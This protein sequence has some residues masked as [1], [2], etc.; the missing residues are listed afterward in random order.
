MN[1]FEEYVERYRKR[2]EKI[3]GAP[4]ATM[5]HSNRTLYELLLR[6]HET[7][8]KEWRAGRPF[9]ITADAAPYDLIEA[10]GMRAYSWEMA[11]DFLM[12]RFVPEYLRRI[13]A[14]GFP[15]YGCD[16]VQLAA[17][18]IQ[19]ADAGE[20]PKPDCVC[21]TRADCNGMTEALVWAGRHFGVPT[22]VLDCPLTTHVPFEIRWEALQY[23]VE[24]FHDMI[25]LF[26]KEIPGVKYDEAKLRESLEIYAQS[27]KYQAKFRELLKAKPCPAAGRDAG[28][29]P[30]LDIVGDPLI[31][32]YYREAAEEIEE[33]VKAGIGGAV[34]EEK[35]R[36]GFLSSFPFF[37]DGFAPLE[38]R[39]VA[40]P[41]YEVGPGALPLP[42]ID[43]ETW[44]R[45]LTPL[46]CQAA[47]PLNDPW[48]GVWQRRYEDVRQACIDLDLDGLVH[49]AMP[50]CETNNGSGRIL[51]KKLEEE[52]GVASVEVEY[53]CQDEASFNQADYVEKMHDFAELLIQ[54]KE[55]KARK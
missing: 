48:L 30:P 41:Y 50:G 31:V 47:W 37:I 42:T 39:G 34:K 23:V 11:G 18:F 19:A 25:R 3:D 33:R 24:Q 17:S 27:R 38:E 4:S 52:L 29:M 21:V 49:Y 51:A 40:C 1:L 7:M 6:R 46:E 36:V 54:R 8:L 13:R 55:D 22:V 43:A 5:L 12:R 26:E 53:H 44:G 14:T 9:C 20:V 35:A 15:D 32:E 45:K 10:M 16:R 2:V 28:R